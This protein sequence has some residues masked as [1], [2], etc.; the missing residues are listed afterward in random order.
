MAVTADDRYLFTGD[1][2]GNLEHIRVSDGRK[3]IQY[4]KNFK[5]G[6]I[7]SMVTTPD[8]KYLFVGESGGDGCGSL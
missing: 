7:S 6:G 2:F 1:S 8:N 5:R 4:L 3:V